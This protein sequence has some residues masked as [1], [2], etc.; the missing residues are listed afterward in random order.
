MESYPVDIDPG[1]IVRWIREEY[2]AA[3]QSFRITATRKEEMRELPGAKEAHLGDEEREDLSEVASI[4]MLE[5]APFNASDGW[6]LK[7]TAVDEAGPRIF[8]ASGVRW[9]EQQID[10][11]TFQKEF[12]RPERGIAD[13]VAEVDGPAAKAR[14][15]RILNMIERNRHARRPSSPTKRR[16]RH[17]MNRQ[18]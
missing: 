3:P 8:D 10:L 4:A 1:Q 15:G 18:R 13:V 7:L 12:M 2:E 14:L 17:S 5:I 9:H 6:L 16:A 11:G